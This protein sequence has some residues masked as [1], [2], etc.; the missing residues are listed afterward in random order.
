M[1]PLST[2]IGLFF[3]ALLLAACQP[4][5]DAA[6][7]VEAYL[8]ALAAKNPD[9]LA[10]AVCAEWEEQALIE[11]SA[12]GSVGVTLDGLDC[13]ATGVDGDYTVV[14]CQ[15]KIIASYSGEGQEFPLDRRLYRTLAEGGEWRVCGYR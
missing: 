5:D 4:G 12:F 10:A 15:G 1:K 2:R 3:L 7:S 9:A 6:G 14:A 11:L 8:Q 13:R